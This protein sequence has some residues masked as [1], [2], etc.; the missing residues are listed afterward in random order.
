MITTLHRS[1]NTV[2]RGDRTARLTR[3]ESDLL[4]VMADLPEGEIVKG[5]TLAAALGLRSHGVHSYTNNLSQALRPVG[6]K[7]QGRAAKQNSGYRLAEF[8]TGAPVRVTV[9]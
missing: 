5:C 4:V 1:T 6:L 2:T 9:E 3:R 8:G 7:V